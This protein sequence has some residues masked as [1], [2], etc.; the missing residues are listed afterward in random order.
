MLINIGIMLS[1]P[2]KTI[3]YVY[4]HVKI[5]VQTLSDCPCPQIFGLLE[6]HLT[7]CG[8]MSL[9]KKEYKYSRLDEMQNVFAFYKAFETLKRCDSNGA[10]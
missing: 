8:F 1:L 7:H 6:F 10:F 2:V 9:L 3:I 5:G 4:G